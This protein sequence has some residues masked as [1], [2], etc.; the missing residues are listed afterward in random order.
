MALTEAITFLTF[1]YMTFSIAACNN[2]EQ[3][4]QEKHGYLSRVRVGRGRIWAKTAVQCGSRALA[5]NYRSVYYL[6]RCSDNKGVFQVTTSN[7]ILPVDR[8]YSMNTYS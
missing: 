2:L 1:K 3:L 4:G 8:D 5:N 7:A 6:L